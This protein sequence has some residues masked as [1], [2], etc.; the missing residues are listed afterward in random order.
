MYLDSSVY[1]G[2]LNM[3]VFGECVLADQK[4]FVLWRVKALLW[5][6]ECFVF[7]ETKLCH[8]IL[9]PRPRTWQEWS[10][11]PMAVCWQCGKAVW[12]WVIGTK[13]WTQPGNMRD[14]SNTNRAAVLPVKTP[15]GLVLATLPTLLSAQLSH[16]DHWTIEIRKGVVGAHW[17]SIHT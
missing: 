4:E 1:F 14:I 13:D 9:R 6:R 7:N 12:K 17:E 3:K 11:P 2:V 8:S 5:V 10:G 15:T 16:K